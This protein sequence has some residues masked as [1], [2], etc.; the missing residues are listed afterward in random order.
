MDIPSFDLKNNFFL[1]LAGVVFGFVFVFE[2]KTC[3]SRS[4]SVNMCLFY[5]VIVSHDLARI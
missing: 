5:L 1:V 4:V 2:H 3:S